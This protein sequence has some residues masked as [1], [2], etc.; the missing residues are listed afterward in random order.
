MDRETRFGSMGFCFGLPK[1]IEM[2]MNE[3]ER[4]E[5]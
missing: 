2:K 4:M 5:M 3:S 1:I